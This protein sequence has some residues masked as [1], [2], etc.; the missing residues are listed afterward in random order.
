MVRYPLYSPDIAPVHLFLCQ[1]MK[2]ELADV[3]LYQESSK[4]SWDGAVWNIPKNKSA[5]AIRR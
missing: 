1:R 2:S 5:A 3:W 4:M